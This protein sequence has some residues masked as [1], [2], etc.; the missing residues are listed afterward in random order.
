[1]RIPQP[2]LWYQQQYQTSIKTIQSKNYIV[3]LYMFQKMRLVLANNKE[4]DHNKD[5]VHTQD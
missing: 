1:M 4:A 3:I 5:I 2:C